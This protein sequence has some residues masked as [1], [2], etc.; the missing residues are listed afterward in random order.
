MKAIQFSTYGDS[1][2]LK[3]A[4]VEKPILKEDEV[5]VKLKATTV[6]P[7]DMKV[8]SGLMQKSS[9]VTFP[10]IPGSD[11][12]GIVEA[13]GSKVT[14][15]KN[16]DEV[17]GTTFGGT[18]AEYAAVKESL[19]ALKPKSI[20]YNDAVALA[21]PINTANTL[22]F[23]K[24]NLQKNQRVLV[25]GAAGAVGNSIVQLAKLAGAYVIG[26]ASG[27]GVELVKKS[28][29]DEVIDY[30]TQDFT[31]LVKNIDL[32]ADTVGGET[33]LKSLEVIKKGGRL[34]SIVSALSSELSEKAGVISL[35]VFSNP[36][37]Q[38][39]DS[40]KQLVEEG[41]LKPGIAR[42]MKLEDA[43]IAQDLVSNGGI[44]GKIVLEIN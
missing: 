35:F 34:L 5:L 13:I 15:L 17:F 39:L 22:L 19:V 23:E 11:L 18:Y 14:R 30:K 28:G 6:N 29:A 26:T 16:G 32:V 43:A 2:V 36:S 1:S 33:Q 3:L 12:A 42:V 41:K 9:P 38:K 20:S 21:V 24:G 37:Y 25:H 31:K 10:F 40:G 27:A 7:F 4:E 8:R 44:N